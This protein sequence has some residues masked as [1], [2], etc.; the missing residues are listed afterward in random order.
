MLILVL[1]A[2]IGALYM[3]SKPHDPLHNRSVETKLLA[4][5]FYGFLFWAVVVNNGM[6]FIIEP[7]DTR[8]S[9][10]ITKIE[11]LSI[12][13]DHDSFNLTFRDS[14]KTNTV[15]KV[16]DITTMVIINDSDYFDKDTII[17][18]SRL[19]K[20]QSTSSNMFLYFKF[21]TYSEILEITKTDFDALPARFRKESG[22]V[23]MLPEPRKLVLDTLK[24][25]S[26]DSLIIKR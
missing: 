13:S 15:I 23:F 2:I 26:K 22:N 18:R 4:G 7:K 9:L 12:T 3:Y 8:L 21:I 20:I 25:K 17:N 11:P 16:K 10:Y 19:I 1:C 6:C 14:T 5:T 24:I